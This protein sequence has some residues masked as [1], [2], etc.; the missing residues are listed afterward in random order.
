MLEET[1][2]FE[3]GS[4]AEGV[5]ISHGARAAWHRLRRLLFEEIQHPIHR[6]HGGTTYALIAHALPDRPVRP[7]VSCE[8]PGAG[9][10][11]QGF[12]CRIWLSS[13]IAAIAFQ[14]RCI[15]FRGRLGGGVNGLQVDGV[16]SKSC[17]SLVHLL[18]VF[19]VN[20]A[21]CALFFARFAV[22]VAVARYAAP[23]TGAD[24]VCFCHS[25]GLPRLR[26]ASSLLYF[27]VYNC[28]AA[29]VD[30]EAD[31]RQRFCPARADR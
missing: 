26:L 2:Q 19:S 14:G 15:A 11:A 28:D 22:A 18:S 8:W 12:A 21:P 31:G 30:M 9:I 17:L 7:A 13:I 6:I 10:V 23:P 20:D 5:S 16:S 24:A 25:K 4:R 1:C 29:L 27:Y 3:T